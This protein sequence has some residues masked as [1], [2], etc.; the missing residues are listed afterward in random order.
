MGLAP[1][2]KRTVAA[3]VV[4]DADLEA[5]EGPATPAPP[6]GRLSALRAG[7]RAPATPL[8]VGTPLP[9]RTRSFVTEKGG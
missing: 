4:P 7:V 2:A 8:A 3:P 6:V 1:S 9:A 5:R